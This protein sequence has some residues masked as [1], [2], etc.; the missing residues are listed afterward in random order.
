MSL[1][2][3]SRR[4]SSWQIQVATVRALFFRELLTRFGTD[5]LRLG[6]IWAVLSPGLQVLMMVVIFSIIKVRVVPNMDYV[7]FLVA[8][9]VPWMLFS[10]SATRALGAVEANKGLFNYRPVLPIDAVIARTLLEGV[11]YF[12]V[13]VL[14]LS[15]LWWLG[16]EIS[17]SHVPLLLVSWLLL[18]LFSLGFALI[19]MV[20]GHW[21]AEIARFVSI[22]IRIMYFISG[23]LYSLHVLPE[24]YL[25]YVLWNP[26]PHVIEHMRHALAPTYP[27]DH[28]SYGYF[29]ASTLVV[30]F[31]GLL[32]YRGAERSMVTTK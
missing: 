20:I 17:V 26:V 8:G 30:M 18:W 10:S 28:V 6:Y 5:Q 11:L 24:E 2:T 7:L 3:K 14:F 9:I 25:A 1:A 13:F 23:I 29:L 12:A 4:R 22:L 32:L 21:S 27:I 16:Y 31:V 15:G 19:M